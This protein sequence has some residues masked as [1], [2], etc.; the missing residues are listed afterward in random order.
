MIKVEI[1]GA[2]SNKAKLKDKAMPLSMVIIV[3]GT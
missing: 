1:V 2:R 3:I